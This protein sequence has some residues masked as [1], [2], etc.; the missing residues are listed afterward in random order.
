MGRFYD[1]PISG[2]AGGTLTWRADVQNGAESLSYLL[3]SFAG[4]QNVIGGFGSLHNANG[5]SPEQIVMQC[6][7]ADMAEYLVRGI[8]LGEARLGLRSIEEQGPGGNYLTDGMTLDLLR[9]GEFFESPYFDMSG[10]YA[11]GAPG[12]Y[13]IAH[14]VVEEVVAARRPAVPSRVDEAIRRFFG[15]CYVDKSLR[16]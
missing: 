13:E 5:M 10:G 14:R 16:E 12:M 4:G 9:G 8:D 2:E 7:L 1:L 11:D 3:A 6:G 15:E